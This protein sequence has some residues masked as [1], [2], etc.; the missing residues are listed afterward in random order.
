MG[1]DE[2]MNSQNYWIWLQKTLGVSTRLDDIIAYFK[3]PQNIYEAG[4]M[5]WRL[6]GVFTPLQI[7]KLQ[8]LKVE[9]T[10][11]DTKICDDNKIRIIT[12]DDDEYPT[13][14]R[15][16]DDF[17][18]V[19][20]VWG[21][22]SIVNETICI[23]MV[24]TRKASQ[25]SALVASSLSSS[26]ASAGAT[27]ISGGALGIDT[28]SHEGAL[29]ANG[30]T[31][32]VLGCG[33]LYKYLM[34]NKPLRDRIAKN[35]AVVS[36][37]S[38]N[39]SADRRTFP[40]RNR[41][42]SGMSLGTVVIEAGEKSG[43]LITASLALDQ[44]RDVFAVP[45][46]VVTSAYNGANKLI[47]DG[48]RPVFSAMDVLEEY[49]YVYPY[50]MDL[51]KASKPISNSFSKQSSQLKVVSQT[52]ERQIKKTKTPVKRDIKGTVSEKA[53]KIYNLFGEEPIHI[54]DLKTK[55]GFEVGTVL[56][57]L[58]ELELYGYISLIQGRKYIL[59]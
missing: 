50:K 24:G 38:P 23:A 49:S 6:S 28:A 17:P 45:G 54:N 2:I 46:D 35:G 41:L 53:L 19:L 5:E 34:E 20:Y 12:P 59:N 4:E 22:L 15:N 31:V 39:H 47:R 1:N 40:I 11:L 16:I 29:S 33:L 48:A 56:S 32:A 58:T 7:K 27:I 10:L 18:A 25:S 55:S 36:E 52:I 13:L 21:D 42:I 44:G 8:S 14:L 51:S 30:K 3:S 57:A 37:F 26:M 9:D 43:S